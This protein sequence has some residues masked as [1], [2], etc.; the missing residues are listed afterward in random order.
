MT[1]SPE[2]CTLAA[3]LYDSKSIPEV[4]AELGESPEA[5]EDAG[6]RLIWAAIV[7]LY[8][9]GDPVD[10]TTIYQ[11]GVE[12]DTVAGMGGGMYLAELFDAGA[13]IIDYMYHVRKVREAW[14][15]RRLERL[16]QRIPNVVRYDGPRAALELIQA[17]IA[18]L[19][20]TDGAEVGD[21]LPEADMSDWEELADEPID[22]TFAEGMAADTLALIVAP[23]GVGKSYLSL[24]LGLSV[25]LGKS[26]LPRFTPMRRGPVLLCFGEDDRRELA[27]R[28]S[29]VCLAHRIDP[30]EVTRAFN[31]GRL[32]LVL[33]KAKALM[34]IGPDGAAKL[35]EAHTELARRCAAKKYRLVVVDPIVKW[36]G[37]T[38]ENDNVQMNRAADAMIDLAMACG[39]CVLGVH[40]QGKQSARER[41]TTTATGRGASA[42]ADASRWQ[43]TL[44]PVN[45]K[46]LGIPE[47]EAARYLELCVGKNSYFER[48]PRP[49]YLERIGGALVG[50]DLS[51]TP[52]D[53]I[54]RVARA[55]ADKIGGNPDNLA[56]WAILQDPPGAELRRELKAE[57]RD[58]TKSNIAKAYALAI[59]RGW[60]VEDSDSDAAGDGAKIP[61]IPAVEVLKWVD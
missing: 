19:G 42:L 40:H 10:L 34:M 7:C 51:C 24:I 48:D 11:F 58:A 18:A 56:K 36:S 33:T 45:H 52:E 6:H 53:A 23:G 21:L 35:T 61:R 39:G 2:S 49:L 13:R 8:K 50:T 5:F 55:L 60:L 3:C 17:E 1:P 4:I 20:G 41:E 44:Q 16:G 32:T 47:A 28:L 31:D 26:L 22:S 59:E 38:N 27:R 30:A 54:A 46:A 15:A 43:A 29:A 57:H 37:V 14:T 12:H 9:D 25:A